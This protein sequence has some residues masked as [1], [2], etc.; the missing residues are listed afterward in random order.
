VPALEGNHKGRPYSPFENLPLERGDFEGS[1]TRSFASF[2]RE[3]FF[4]FVSIHFLSSLYFGTFLVLLGYAKVMAPGVIILLEVRATLSTEPIVLT[5]F[6][7]G[8]YE[9]PYY[10][11]DGSAAR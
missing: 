3:A 2:F 7:A 1:F 9:S 5:E 11:P 8:Y 10:P 4:N 6:V